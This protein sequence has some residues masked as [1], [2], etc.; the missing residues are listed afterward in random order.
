MVESA[1]KFKNLIQNQSMYIYELSSVKFNTS[2]E[3]APSSRTLF[4]GIKAHNAMNM[5]VSNL[6]EPE[7]APQSQADAIGS[8]KN[9]HIQSSTAAE[10]DMSS[11]YPSR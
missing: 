4:H 11:I 10:D 1:P 6:R 9:M 2:R 5:C 3:Q 7:I 8:S